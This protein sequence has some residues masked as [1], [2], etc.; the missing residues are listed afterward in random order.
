MLF[1]NRLTQM[2]STKAGT[3]PSSYASAKD[4]RQNL[5]QYQYDTLNRQT[6]V[7]YPNSTTAATAY[8]DAGRVSSRTDLAGKTTQYGYD[9]LG[10]L[11]SVTDAL[12]QV[13]SYGYDELGNRIS[14]TDANQHTTTYAYDQ[15]GRRSKR[16]LPLGQSES[17]TY[18]AEGNLQART[19]FNGKTT[20]YAYDASNRLL[21]KAPDA[22]FNAA[23]V[24]FT[25]TVTGKRQTMSDVSGLTTYSYDP[26]NDRLFSKQTPEGTLTYTYDAGGNVLSI[27]SSN[28]NGAAMTYTYDVLNRLASVAVPGQGATTYS[29][30]EV[31]NL[32]GYSYPNG[33]ATSYAYDQLN[34]LSQMGSQKSGTALASYAYTLGA[35]GNRT[36][37]AEL[38]GR[39]VNY[40]YDSLYRLTSEAI[41]NDPANHNDTTQYLYDPVGNRKQLIANG[42]IVNWYTYDADDRLGTD[43][44]DANGNTIGSLG[45]AN[46]YD[47]ENHLAQ[48][49]GGS[50]L[51]D[52]DGNRV[53]ETV[54]GTTTKYLVDTHNPT[55]YVQVVDELQNG[56]VVRSYTW[57]SQLI[58]ERQP[59]NGTS[60]TSYYGFDGHGN[61]RF[62]TN[63]AGTV[64]DSYDY[65]AFGNL[66]SQTGTTPN[67]YLFAGEQFD[68]A[69]G[70]Y[71]NRARYLD[72]R[73]GRFW[74]MDSYEGMPGDPRSLHKYLY[75]VDDPVD[76]LDPSGNQADMVELGIE[77]GGMMTGA[78]MATPQLVPA[79]T[80]AQS[81]TAVAAIKD[82]ILLLLSASAIAAPII[83]ISVQQEEEDK[84]QRH[85]GRLQVQGRDIA[86]QTFDLSGHGDFNYSGDTLSWP[87]SQ[88]NPLFAYTACSKLS[89]FL[90]ILNTQQIG[91]R[92]TAFVQAS[93]FIVNASLG[94]G[95]YAPTSMN[96]Q[97]GDKVAP[98]ARVDIEVNAGRAFVPGP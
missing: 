97:A 36:T 42:V 83:A 74:G 16:T 60:T 2:G 15:L 34:R 26:K 65:D 43:Q 21:S 37:V 58:S 88:S 22:S 51:Y 69:L 20:T 71:Y 91:R 76:R 63:S 11:T 19:D 40:G 98:D 66:I 39:T 81:V 1:E 68:P 45:T 10:R 50:I 23:P 61:V 3:A 6:A 53:V 8:D 93:R 24:A 89:E 41:A 13:T 49:G 70:L 75:A 73:V 85:G 35:A 64:T 38:S 67:N 25:Y 80:A 78:A 77:E 87:W 92:A 33:V 72:V 59:M 56:S 32:A 57:G 79:V 29:Y 18:D 9:K 90:Q 27:T 82:T 46:V 5:T 30:D 96:F 14:Q 44:Y 86:G 84:R 94:G 28:A 48:P 55:G 12:G 52:G 62:L 31:G 7:V 17:Y 4:A 47:F 54:A 95:V